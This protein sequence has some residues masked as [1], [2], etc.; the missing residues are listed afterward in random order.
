MRELDL[1]F[2]YLRAFMVTARHLNFSKAAFELNIAQSAVSRQIKL[3]EEAIGEQLIIRSSKKVVLT[4]KGE[5]LLKLLE[6]FEVDVEQAFLG[7]G[8]HTLRVGIL[9]G[10]LETW[11]TDIIAEY[12]K[13]RG[14]S[15][16][17]E[18]QAME[19]LKEKLLG[20]SYDMVFTTENIQSELV[21]SLRLFD[22]KLVMVSKG[23]INPKD[24][25]SY[26]WIVYNMNDNLMHLFKKPS[27]QI[28]AVNSITSVI[29]LVKKGAGIAIVPDHMLPSDS[30]LKVYD[31]KGL[32]KAS[33][34]L[35]TLNF[36]VLPEH[37]KNLVD[38]TKKRAP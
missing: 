9:H 11:F 14:R 27:K 3:L 8:H 24:A 22:E 23:E 19:K 18:I 25:P 20:G 33:V 34:Y 17:V 26:P 10:L 37:L 28:I 6:K 16:V 2:R 32:P 1:D 36:R 15:L 21:S 38:L 29:S 30:N 13:S 5:S 31:L 4:E 7:Q 12:A 35:S